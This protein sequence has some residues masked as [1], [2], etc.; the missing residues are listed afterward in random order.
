MATQAQ[1]D[2]NRRNAEKSTGPTTAEGVARTRFNATTH[3]LGS[4]MAFM[5]DE[6]TAA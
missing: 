2:A 4:H 5:Q 1:I 6:R 3:A